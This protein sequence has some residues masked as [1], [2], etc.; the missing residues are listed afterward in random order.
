MADIPLYQMSFTDFV[1]AVQP[2]GAINRFPSVGKSADV[3]MYRVYMNGEV[4]KTLPKHAQEQTFK[5]VTI[6]A[7]SEKMRLNP[8]STRDNLKVAEM[9]A[10]RSAYMTAVLESSLGMQPF[11]AEVLAD[12]E[13]LSKGLGHPWIKEELNKQRELS[14]RLSQT[15]T[16]FGVAKDVIPNE[17]TVGKVMA[18]DKNFTLQQEPS[19][20]VVTHENRRLQILPEVG[21]EAMVSYYRG[22]GQVVQGQAKFSEPFV[23]P[24]TEDLAVKV[25]NPIGGIQKVVLFNNVQSYA[26]FVQAHGLEDRLVQSAF[27]VR[28]MRPKK[29]FKTP[30]RVP[31]SMPYMDLKSRS[32]AIDYTEGGASY[33]AIF[34]NAAKMASLSREFGIGAK[35][36]AEA[37]RIE[38]VHT[39][40][41]KDVPGQQNPET[42]LLYSAAGM[43]H[44]LRDKGYWSPQTSDGN[45]DRRYVGPVVAVTE[46]HI[47][48][49]IGRTQVVVHDVRTLDKVPSVGDH[50][51]IRFKDGRG[52]VTDMVKSSKDRGR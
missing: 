35:A 23:D 1:Q 25:T 26:Q 13:T 40:Q 16:R 47:A 34:E 27:N 52:I 44:L 17:V 8:E 51:N 39:Q 2:S 18:Q 46:M 11:A 6:Q 32:L 7:L 45:P 12:Y 31:V 14:D 24:Q 15:L 48:Q 20:Q 42:N 43:R 30:D 37:H 28:A 41:T 21:S 38:G 22:G 50:L 5:D 19:G 49:D 36:I 3:Y 29:D 33:T 10:L 9:V 4:G